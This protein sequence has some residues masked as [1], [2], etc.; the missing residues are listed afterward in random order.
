MYATRSLA[1]GLLAFLVLTSASNIATATELRDAVMADNGAAVR[2]LVKQGANVNA[3]EVDGT[4]PLHWAVRG[5][6]LEL[7]SLLIEAK[8]NVRA[9][10][11]YG[12]TPLYV[13]CSLANAALAERLLAAGADANALDQSGETL[14]SLATRAGAPDVVTA[15]LNH[16]A[17]VNAPMQDWQSTALMVAIRENET[18]IVKILLDH[19][20]NINARTKAGQKPARRPQGAGG[21]SHGVGI[22]RSGIPENGSQ[23]P[24]QG[25]FTPLL[26]AARD[27]RIDMVQSLVAKNADLEL[28]EANGIT[29]LQMAIANENIA[30]ARYLLDRGANPNSKDAYGRTPLWLAVELRNVEIGPNRTE[31]DNGVDREATLGLVRD[32]I[33]RGANVNARTTDWPP[34]R[35][36]LMRL[37]DLSWVNF[38]GQTP[39][40]RAAM[41]GDVTTMKL[42]LENGADP[43]IETEEGTTPLMAAAGINWVVQQ[44]YT[45]SDEAILN[46]VKLC[47]D[48]GADINH[49][50]S[51]GLTAVH[52][53]ANRGSD[54]I[55]QFLADHG[56]KMDAKDKEGRTPYVWAEGVFLATNAPMARPS[57]MALIKKLVGEK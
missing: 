1:Q 56:A 19:G 53:A 29:P 32:L 23:T 34:T 24:A 14:L 26:Y 18:G 51:M 21:G 48:L 42:L 52:G 25:G 31:H 17:N 11:R 36:H 47:L 38:I 4:T 27:G 37:G 57:S 30:L 45:E 8:A 9:A 46:A 40:L 39:F 13:A 12:V 44:T 6:N 33:T 10:D 41:S 55:I 15:L 49:A 3:A 28:A 50:N 22:S 43:K 54:H 16:G 35:R 2:S 5:E 20:A 7:V